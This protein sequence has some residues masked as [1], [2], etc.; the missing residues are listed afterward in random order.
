[1]ICF[2]WQKILLK[3]MR[4]QVSRY[5]QLSRS[6]TSTAIKRRLCYLINMNFVS[7]LFSNS[8]DKQDEGTP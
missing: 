1:M 7:A 4:E 6:F 5:G 8:K 2:F 3:V